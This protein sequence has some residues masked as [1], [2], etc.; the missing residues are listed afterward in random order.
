MAAAAALWIAAA[1]WIAPAAPKIT[2]NDASLKGVD[3]SSPAVWMMG[4]IGCE[5][6]VDEVVVVVGAMIELLVVEFIV[7]LLASSLT[8][9]IDAV[10]MCPLC[11]ALSTSSI[12]LCRLHSLVLNSKLFPLSLTSDQ[13]MRNS[14]FS[15]FR[16][17]S[18]CY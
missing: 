3:A 14:P 10:S 12:A 5:F 11:L 1:F 4:T 16:S 2:A 7:N 8:V 15:F 13:A 9:A 6:A 17:K 18:E